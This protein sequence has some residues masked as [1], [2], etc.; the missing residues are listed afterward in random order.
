MGE[1][2]ID[3]N[4]AFDSVNQKIK[5]NKTYIEV[6]QD[7]AKLK[8]DVKNNLEKQKEKVTTTVNTLK[9]NKKRYQR[10]V[11]T[12]IDKMME[13][14]QMNS[15]SGSST[16]RYIK[17]KFNEIAVRIGPKIFDTLQ[18]ESINS[19]G[20]SAQ[21]S[22]DGTQSLYIKVK[23]TDLLNLLKRNPN[24]EVAAVAYEKTPP[25][26]STIPYSMNREM[27]ERLQNLNV[28]ESFYGASGQ[29]L[30]EISYVQQDGNGITGDF[31]KIKL[32]S[33]VNGVNKVGDFLTD[34]YKAIQI[35][36][37]NN[38]F[39]QLMD[40][41]SG[42]ISIDAK[43]GYGELDE[44]NKFVLI[45]QRI[46]GLCFDSKREID[47]TGNSKVAELDGI[48][49]SFFEFTDID[50]RYIE[51]TI[52]NIQNGVVEFED[53]DNIKLPVDS[54]SI[55]ESLIKFNS[56]TNVKDE[57]EL[58]NQLTTILT[59]NDKWKLPNSID[60]NV[61]VDLSFLINMP[62]AIM[63]ALLSPKVLLPIMIMSKA[64]GQT[65]A[66]T[67][68]SLMDFMKAFKKYVIALMSKIGAV[69]VQELFQII[70]RDIKRLVGEILK[71]I[72]KEKV[73]KVYSI[74]LVLVEL[75]LLVARFI[76]DWRKC[77]SVVDEILALLNLVR[78]KGASIPSPL[79]AASELLDGYSESR[80]FINVIS[81]YQKIGLPTGVMPDGSPNLMLQAKFAEIKG[82]Q[83]EQN[84][85]GKVQVFVKPLTITPAGITLPSGSIFGKPM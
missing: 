55:L 76:D 17:S 62:K 19:L 79:L 34:Y 9:E 60:I 65:V 14:I 5:A 41:I 12:Q 85:N 11:K 45:L 58:A 20:C 24:D 57:E 36:D 47:I 3:L 54:K 27:W 69:F 28:P 73:L 56:I 35:V 70:K 51:N 4:S 8:R 30:F 37:T 43:L 38:L 46:L 83:K 52:S 2:S 42:A 31:F 23:S 44:K 22:Y 26:S 40:Q 66:D 18:K 71:D 68:E 25:T 72:K 64:I 53:C 39:S 50:L 78:G 75:I 21:Q 77:K 80:G 49:E 13:V 84:E 15:G 6:K 63:M 1:A 59:Q 74:I 81:E 82:H 48:D 32:E 16:M 29:K 33:K 10:Q 67:V 61:S 7:A